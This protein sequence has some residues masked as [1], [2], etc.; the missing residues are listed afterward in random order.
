[1]IFALLLALYTTLGAVEQSTDSLRHYLQVAEQ[2]SATVQ[3]EWQRYQASKERVRQA[4]AY[5]DPE[6][7]VGTYLQAMPTLMGR[8]LLDIS[9]MQ[10][11]PWFGSKPAARREAGAMANMAYERYRAERDRVHYEVKS[12]W[13]RLMSLREQVKTIRENITLLHQLEQLALRKLATAGTVSSSRAMSM[14][15]RSVAQ[16]V[17]MASSSMP[18]MSS[19][20]GSKPPVSSTEIQGTISGASGGSMS[21]M[22]ANAMTDGGRMSDVLRLQLEAGELDEQLLSLVEQERL[23]RAEFNFLL[24]RSVDS[25]IALGDTL[26]LFIQE[27][28]ALLSELYARNPMLSMARAEEESVRAKKEMDRLM[29]LPMFGLGLQ[30]S[31]MSGGHTPQNGGHVAGR[32]MIMPMIKL[33][34]PIFRGKYNAQRRENEYNL[35]ALSHKQTDIRQQIQAT[36]LDLKQKLD[37]GV[38]K[39]ALYERQYQL[40]LSTWSLIRQEFVAGKQA[41]SEVIAVERQL[42]DYR[43]RRIEAIAEYNMQVA[44]MERL[45]SISNNEIK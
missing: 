31:V 2:A 40:L 3:A 9:L 18:G 1:M 26:T 21:A 45:L 44:S 34:L 6:V 14:P 43:L 22:Q 35:Q 8:Q 41:L 30:Y 23:Q 15:S 10:M 17:S 5:P 25:P 37:A 36:H 19:M 32:D 16:G 28:S 29:G 4:G 38:R 20:M 27:P 7:E 13:Y 24:N 33:S 11:F 42:L 12:K 39:I